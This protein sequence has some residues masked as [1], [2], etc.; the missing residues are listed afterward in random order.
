MNEGETCIEAALHWLPLRHKA[1]L[2]RD[3]LAI[4]EH[5]YP[6]HTMGFTD[7]PGENLFLFDLNTKQ[8]L[9]SGHIFQIQTDDPEKRPLPSFSLLEMQWHLTR[10]VAMQGAS[11]SDDSDTQSDDDI[12]TVSSRSGSRSRSPGKDGSKMQENLC[13]PRSRTQ[14]IS[15][16]PSLK[17]KALPII[18]ENDDSLPQ[19]S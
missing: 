12:L 13:P 16:S 5:P 6:E 4:E 2:Q 8:V 19:T 14:S 17:P 10:I 3:M 18:I 9:P 11:E 7:S 15:P 1:I